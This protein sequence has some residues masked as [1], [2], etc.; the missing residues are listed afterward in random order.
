MNVL[1]PSSRN[2]QQGIADPHKQTVLIKLIK[3]NAA[4]EK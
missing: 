4:R 1:F 2:Y 3:L